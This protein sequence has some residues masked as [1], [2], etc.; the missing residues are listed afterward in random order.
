MILVALLIVL[1]QLMHPVWFHVRNQQSQAMSRAKCTVHSVAPI[2]APSLVPSREPSALPSA[3]PNLTKI[4]R[5]GETT[6]IG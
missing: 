3:L 1:L 6:P 5:E 2:D 4:P